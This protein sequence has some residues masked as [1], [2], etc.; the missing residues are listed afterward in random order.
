MFLNASFAA[1]CNRL[2]PLLMNEQEDKQDTVEIVWD[3]AYLKI[4]I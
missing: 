4:I 1:S 3:L 2:L